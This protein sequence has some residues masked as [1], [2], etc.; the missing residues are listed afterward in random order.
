MFPLALRRGDAV[1]D[2]LAP[3]LVLGNLCEMLHDWFV[4]NG[5]AVVG[6]QEDEALAEDMIATNV[7]AQLDYAAILQ[8]FVKDD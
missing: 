6:F 7:A 4:D 2:D 3:M 5:S 8:G 1:F